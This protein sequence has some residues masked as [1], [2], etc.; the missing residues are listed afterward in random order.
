MAHNVPA[1]YEAAKRF[2][3]GQEMLSAR[4]INCLLVACLL[5]D[6]YLRFFLNALAF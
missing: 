5:D 3:E 1:I 2:T 4:C 6:I